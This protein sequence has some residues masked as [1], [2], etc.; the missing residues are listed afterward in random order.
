MMLDLKQGYHQMLLHED[1][2]PRTA[3]STLLAPLQ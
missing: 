2:M 3:M 1:P